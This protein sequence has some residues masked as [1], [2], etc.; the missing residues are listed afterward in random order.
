MNVFLALAISATVAAFVCM[1]AS[2]ALHRLS[3]RHGYSGK[4]ERAFTQAQ[5]L[6][7]VSSLLFTIAF[8]FSIGSLMSI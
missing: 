2:Y 4:Y 5:L 8:A 7:Y 3:E 6:G 1:A